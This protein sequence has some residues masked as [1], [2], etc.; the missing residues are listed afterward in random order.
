M[1]S[2]TCTCHSV[3][4][5]PKNFII[6]MMACLAWDGGVLG[7]TRSVSQTK[8]SNTWVTCGVSG[9]HIDIDLDCSMARLLG[10]NGECECGG[11]P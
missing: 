7:V 5:L 11:V 4:S 8:M 9:V 10:I 2:R 6:A 1:C 3:G